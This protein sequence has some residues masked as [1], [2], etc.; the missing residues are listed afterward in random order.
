MNVP[1]AGPNSNVPLRTPAKAGTFGAA[2][3]VV[4][5]SSPESGAKAPLAPTRPR[6]LPPRAALLGPHLCG[7]FS[8]CR[9]GRLGAKFRRAEF[10]SLA[11][12]AGHNLVL[13]S[14]YLCL[15]HEVPTTITASHPDCPRTFRVFAL[16]LGIQV[17][18]VRGHGKVP[19]SGQVEV[20]GGG[21]VK[22]PT[23]CS[24]CRSGA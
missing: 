13:R 16:G 3:E 21:R 20:P 6:C 24:S 2:T 22:V 8:S 19:G 15:H 7:C 14:G 18:G 1:V 11:D 4:V 17:A 9:C 12:D 23:P 5:G 10:P